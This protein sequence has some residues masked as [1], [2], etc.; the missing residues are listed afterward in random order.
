MD[1][2]ERATA[3]APPRT[4]VDAERQPRPLHIVHTE[5]STGWGGQE[6]RILTEAEGMQRRGHR[7]TLLC[8]AHAT[9]YAEAQR[10]GLEVVALP[11]G[12][13]KPGG[14]FAVRHWLKRHRVD[15]INTHSSTDSW[16]A[17][18]AC[19]L[20]RHPPA[21]VR[22][23]HIS[24]AVRAS[25]ANRWLYLHS[26]ARVITTG[27][28]LRQDLLEGLEASSEHIISVPTGI[29][30]QRFTPGDRLEARRAVGL[31]ENGQLIGIVATLR[32]WKGHDHL[33]EAFAAMNRPQ[34]Q[35]VMVGEGP[36][37]EPISDHIRRL[38]IGD[39]VVMPGNQSDVT[40]WIRALDVFVLP[41]FANEGVPQALMQAMACRI[42]VVSTT[43]GSIP[44]IVTQ[45]RTGLLVPPSD[46]QALAAALT[47]MLD[48]D[49]LRK[50]LADAGY[51]L[52]QQHFSIDI[53]LD[54]MEA[55]FRMACH[56]R[57]DHSTKKVS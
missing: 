11:I 18:L 24:T 9:I 44:E 41:S 26:A 53:M 49:A 2:S 42:P 57:E 10:R 12:R 4:G 50:R 7:V 27:E 34:T 48:D 51:A 40:D 20:L 13:K 19:R 30:L 22:T 52:A 36:R 55:L 1:A 8:P 38:D 31:S 33:L 28:K 45:E 6:I 3:A 56:A 15:V 47:R 43:V 54:R 14:V 16:L 37:R 5:A 35:L 46:P 21:I 25:R 32:S 17:G 29:D 39:R 23:R